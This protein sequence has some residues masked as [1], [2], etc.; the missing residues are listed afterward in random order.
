[1]IQ[2]PGQGEPTKGT[3]GAWANRQCVRV[4]RYPRGGTRGGQ[5]V[6]LLL[7]LEIL[8]LIRDV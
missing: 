4:D 5:L 1:M 8:E 7:Q 6:N 3:S 2:R